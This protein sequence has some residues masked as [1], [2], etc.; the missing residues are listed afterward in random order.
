MENARK[1]RVQSS[2]R[3]KFMTGVDREGEMNSEAHPSHCSEL[4]VSAGRLGEGILEFGPISYPNTL[5][6]PDACTT[7]S[8]QD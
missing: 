1:V 2:I 8:I 7:S 6:V 3:T 4:E 5:S